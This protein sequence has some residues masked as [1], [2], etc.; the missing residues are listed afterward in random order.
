MCGRFTLR[1]S[2]ESLAQHFDLAASPE[3]EARYNIA[4]GQSVAMLRADSAR[5]SLRLE[6]VRWGLVPYWAEDAAIGQRMINARA[7]TVAEKPAFRSAFR[8]RRCLLP[9]DGFY[10]WGRGGDSAKQPHLFTRPDRG[11]F[12]F[13]GLFEVWHPGAKDEVRSST[14]ITTVANGVVAEVHDRMPVIVDPYDYAAWLDPM[15]GDLAALQALL[16]PS[17]DDWLERNTVG[18]RVNNTRNDDPECMQP[19]APQPRQAELL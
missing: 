12:A 8:K 6:H 18:T 11:L 19:A 13:A 10:E 16:V 5:A 1:A 7:E 2:P 15:N 3:I 9:A 4:P 17:P 14:I